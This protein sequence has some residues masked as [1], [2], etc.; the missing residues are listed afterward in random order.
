MHPAPRAGLVALVLMIASVPARG[1]TRGI[2][3]TWGGTSI[4]ADREHYPACKDE[5]VV[6][7]AQVSHTSPDTV[8]IRADKIVDGTREFMGEYA[9]TLQGDSAWA[10]EVR[11]PRYHLRLT[12]KQA[13]D[14]VTG[15]LTDLDSAYRIRDIA[16]ERTN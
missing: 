15:T 1:Q 10:C 12:L 6:Y 4:C 11:T 16:L 9:C 8:S 5:Q 2:V 3:G 14:R 7:D 13:G